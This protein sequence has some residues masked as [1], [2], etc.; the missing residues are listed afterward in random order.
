MAER[1]VGR[2]ALSLAVEL[3]GRNH[4]AASPAALH[5]H[6]VESQTLLLITRVDASIISLQLTHF[7]L[8]GCELGYCLMQVCAMSRQ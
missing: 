5:N 2:R 8:R 3:L 1:Y 4:Q 7:V 6:H